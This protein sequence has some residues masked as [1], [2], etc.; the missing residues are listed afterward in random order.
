LASNG[1]IHMAELCF[2]ASVLYGL[3]NEHS[4]SID[5]KDIK[6][7]F[8]NIDITQENVIFDSRYYN[9][10][11]ETIFDKKLEGDDPELSKKLEN[12]IDSFNWKD[13]MGSALA[14]LESPDFILDEAKLSGCLNNL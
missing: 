9:R 12:L 10:I 6:A 3:S 7:V 4:L 1:K 8:K 13:I 14:V 11:N 5:P 2:S